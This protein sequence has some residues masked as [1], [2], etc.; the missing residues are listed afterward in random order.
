LQAE[1]LSRHFRD[2][3]AALFPTYSHNGRTVSDLLSPPS[4]T[5]IS[6]YVLP[7]FHFFLE[8]PPLSPQLCLIVEQRILLM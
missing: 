4:P 2:T 1:T 5:V 7:F 6:R 3:F 8:E